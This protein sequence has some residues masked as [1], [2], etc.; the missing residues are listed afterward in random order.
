MGP[1]WEAAAS[2]ASSSGRHDA[3]RHRLRRVREAEGVGGGDGGER[4]K[5]QVGIGSW[6]QPRSGHIDETSPAATPRLGMAP[7][8]LRGLLAVL[9]GQGHSKKKTIALNPALPRSTLLHLQKK[10]GASAGAMVEH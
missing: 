8:A 6:A 10:E 1:N 3:P 4:E 5:D 9:P 2:A 7:A